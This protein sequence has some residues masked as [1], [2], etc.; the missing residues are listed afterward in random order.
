MSKEQSAP[1]LTI[2][3]ETFVAEYLVDLNATQAAIRAGYSAKTA[4]E[5]GARLLANVSVQKLIQE[6]MSQRAERLEITSDYVLNTIVDTIER[7]RQ[8]KPV[9]D[10]SGKPVLVF[11][12][13]DQTIAPMYAFD[14]GAVLK[15]SELLGKHLKL[16]TDKTEV[17]GKDGK[18]LPQNAPI[19]N[20]TLNK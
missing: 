10:K 1:K 3:Q 17:T 19:L 11:N 13:N 2:K 14:P 12:E 5:Q 18:D 20:L 9:L 8:A 4:N 15:G 16:F 6:R 7:C